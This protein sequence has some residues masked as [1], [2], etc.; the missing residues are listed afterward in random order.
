MSEITKSKNDKYEL[1]E[2]LLMQRDT[3]SREAGSIMT[4]YIKEF[5][6]LITDSFQLKVD[7]IELKK[8]IG[9][10]QTAI[11]HGEKPNR[12]KLNK[13]IEKVMQE[14]YVALEQMVKEHEEALKA[15]VSS[16]E[17]IAECKEIYREIAKMIHPDLHPELANEEKVV[18]LWN[19]TTE[20]Y[21]LNNLKELQEILV[22]IKH[23]IEQL[24]LGNVDIEIP[25]IE[26]KI[27]D[28]EKEINEIKTTEPYIFREILEDDIRFETKKTELELEIKELETY[29]NELEEIVASFEFEEVEPCQMS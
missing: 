15:K 13:Y 28:V 14:Y 26:Q 6:Q 16:P 3:L 27:D 11:N 20:A 9:F 21:H 29:K 19:R 24:G 12:A 18:E 17:T 1:Y 4:A 5:G 2:S 22:L 23:V 7:C 8:T 10:C 25:D